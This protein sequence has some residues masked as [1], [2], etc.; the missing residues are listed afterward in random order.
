MPMKKHAA[1]IYTILG[2]AVVVGLLAAASMSFQS[3]ETVV[4]PMAAQVSDNT[5]LIPIAHGV[6]TGT[7]A[8]PQQPMNY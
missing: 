2:M 6:I 3:K 8:T 7:T 4:E 1:I 5:N